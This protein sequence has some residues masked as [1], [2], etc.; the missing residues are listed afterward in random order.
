MTKFHNL[1]TLSTESLLWAMSL[2]NLPDLPIWPNTFLYKTF[3]SIQT[4]CRAVSQFL[5]CLNFWIKVW[6]RTDPLPPPFVKI[7]HMNVVFL[8]NGFPKW[9]SHTFRFFILS[10][11]K[12]YKSSSAHGDK[13]CVFYILPETKWISAFTMR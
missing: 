2:A 13:L 12:K 10:L 6:K 3:S 4:L 9:V 5:R 8:K 1:P 11:Q 7:F